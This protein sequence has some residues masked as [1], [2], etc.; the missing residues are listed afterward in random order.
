MIPKIY[1]YLKRGDKLNLK[2][3]FFAEKVSV[4]IIHNL[5]LQVHS[6]NVK[7]L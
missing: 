5:G 7:K 2:C 6:C 3:T 4:E 1:I